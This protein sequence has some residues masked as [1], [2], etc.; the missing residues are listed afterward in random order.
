MRASTP[1]RSVLAARRRHLDALTGGFGFRFHLKVHEATERYGRSHDDLVRLDGP[2]TRSYF[3]GKP[4]QLIA[5]HHLTVNL[6]AVPRPTGE[7]GVVES[8][9]W[10]GFNHQELGTPRAGITQR[11]ARWCSG[12]H[13]GRTV[14]RRAAMGGHAPSAHLASLGTLLDRPLPWRRYAG[15]HLGGHL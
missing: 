9:N 8:S 1:L 2:G 13:S 6:F 4:Y 15:H 3:H 5:D 12:M 14:P 10:E 11:I 7:I